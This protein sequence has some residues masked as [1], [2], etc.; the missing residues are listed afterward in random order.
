MQHA[1]PAYDRR[2]GEGSDQGR[3][4]QR[5]AQRCRATEGS[6]RC[7]ALAQQPAHTHCAVGRPGERGAA[8]VAGAGDGVVRAPADPGR[9]APRHPCHH[10]GSGAA[11]GRRAACGD[12]HHPGHVRPGGWCAAVARRTDGHPARHGEGHPR[13]RRRPA[14]PGAAHARRP[15]VRPLRGRQWPRPRFHRR[16]LSVPRAGLVPAHRRLARRLV[17]RALSQPDRRRRVD[18]HLQHA[19]ARPRPWRAHARHGQPGP[20]A[21][22]PDRD[23]RR[24]GAPAGLAGLAGGAGRHA[25]AQS[26]GGRGAAG[27][28]GRLHRPRGPPRPGRSRPRGAPAPATAV[29]A[30]RRGQP[31]TPL[32]R[33][34]TGRRQRLDP[35]W[36]RSPTSWS[37]RA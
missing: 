30:Y 1:A 21:G 22:Q 31:G 17:V 26:R 5:S 29:R 37:W 9:R 27:D 6:R 15:A 12:H 16:R 20:A 24:A 2:P 4:A 32:H 10:A 36:W 18:G 28:A 11:A 35:C 3:H 8:A 34:G 23:G 25:G 33:G 13:L 14:D 7:R 19:A